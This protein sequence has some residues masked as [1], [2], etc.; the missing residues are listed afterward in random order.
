M[1][2]TKKPEENK[3]QFISD[4]EINNILNDYFYEQFLDDAGTPREKD[5]R[6]VSIFL[7][8]TLQLL[9]DKSIQNICSAMNLA[10]I[11][12]QI[13]K[14][15]I[16]GSADTVAKLTASQQK[17]KLDLG[18]DP[19]TLAQRKKNSLGDDINAIIEASEFFNEE[20]EIG[21]LVHAKKLLKIANSTTAP[22]TQGK[23]KWDTIPLEDCR[24]YL[25]R[26]E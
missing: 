8:D 14:N 2:K 20:N 25:E 17:L 9:L 1:A 6:L 12:L 26:V 19:K 24:K 11:T 15:A 23:D 4:P 18:I 7:K 13:N 16:I 5:I 10:I 3:I 21:S 22:K